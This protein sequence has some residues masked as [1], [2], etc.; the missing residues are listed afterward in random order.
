MTQPPLL[1]KKAL[2]QNCLNWFQPEF[3]KDV[4][5]LIESQF[6]NYTLPHEVQSV[7]ECWD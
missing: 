3:R 1:G 2:V 6:P 7:L 4:V 5:S